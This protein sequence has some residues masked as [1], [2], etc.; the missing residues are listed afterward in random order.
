LEHVGIGAGSL[1]QPQFGGMSGLGF[2]AKILSPAVRIVP[3]STRAA[4]DIHQCAR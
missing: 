2:L 3:D 1:S 4:I